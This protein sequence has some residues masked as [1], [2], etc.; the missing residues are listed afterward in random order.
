M[1]TAPEP[2]AP[3]GGRFVFTVYNGYQTTQVGAA[4]HTEAVSLA[5][6]LRNEGIRFS[7]PYTRD[8]TY[9][10][11]AYFTLVDTLDPSGQK[12]EP[13]AILA[14]AFPSAVWT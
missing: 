12:G 13:K 14:E 8:A 6:Q 4:T 7:N 3:T 5:R 1:A 10:V 11:G 2:K 9:W